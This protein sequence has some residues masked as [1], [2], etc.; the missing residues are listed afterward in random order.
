MLDDY[1]KKIENLIT[2]NHYDRNNYKEKILSGRDDNYEQDERELKFKSNRKP[3]IERIE[4]KSSKEYEKRNVID[5][6]RKENEGKLEN[7]ELDNLLQRSIVKSEEIKES[8]RKINGK[9]YTDDDIESLLEKVKNLNMKNMNYRYEIEKYKNKITQ[10]QKDYDSQIDLQNKMEK[11]KEN[12]TKYLLKLEK[13]LQNQSQRQKMM[14]TNNSNIS[15]I[16]NN[17][18]MSLNATKKSVSIFNTSNININV[19]GNNP[20]ITI[21]DNS[22]NSK[23]TILSREELQNF[24][25]KIYKENQKLKAFQSQV[26]ELSKNY[27]DVNSNIEESLKKLQETIKNNKNINNNNENNQNNNIEQEILSQFQDFTNKINNILETKQLEYNLLLKGKDDEL[28][29]ISEELINVS[30]EL[31]ERKSDRLKEQKII[32][33]LENEIKELKMQNVYKESNNKNNNNYDIINMKSE[34]EAKKVTEPAKKAVNNI[35]KNIEANFNMNDKANV[36]LI[37]DINKTIN[38]N[39]NN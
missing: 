30:K 22:K 24:L 33:D 10:L 38:K 13:M 39:N 32:F 36:K 2:P 8:T 5:K 18:N 9:E 3:K 11:E 1:I 7:P 28:N 19:T 4:R 37:G 6:K 35:I 17:Q 29:I 15:T 20:I 21:I 16:S 12:L 25:L 31:E 23:Y 26:F 27:D 14:N 34:K